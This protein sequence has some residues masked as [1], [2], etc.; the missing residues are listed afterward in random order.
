M[1]TGASTDGGT[2]DT[3]SAKDDDASAART[4]ME[5]KPHAWACGAAAC[6][7]KGAGE[8]TGDISLAQASVRRRQ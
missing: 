3:L 7:R 4:A 1:R 5:S 2:S 8:G 6:G